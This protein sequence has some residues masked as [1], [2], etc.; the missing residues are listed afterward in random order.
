MTSILAPPAGAWA[1]RRAYAAVWEMATSH[2]LVLWLE[3][4]ADAKIA[5]VARY[6]GT[7]TYNGAIRRGWMAGDLLA[8]VPGGLMSVT[9]P[10][11]V[12]QPGDLEIA[13]P[14]QRLEIS[15]YSAQVWDRRGVIEDLRDNH[16]QIL[17]YRQRLL[18]VYETEDEPTQLAEG[19]L[20]RLVKDRDLYTLEVE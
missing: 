3:A 1:A 10:E 18:V 14:G 12:I 15:P 6:D 20:V 11:V 7:Y 4:G 13:G 16:V 5:D 19:K 9:A 17:G 2:G 8:V